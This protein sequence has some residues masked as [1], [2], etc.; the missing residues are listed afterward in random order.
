VKRWLPPNLRSRPRPR[1]GQPPE[2]PKPSRAEQACQAVRLLPASLRPN[3]LVHGRRRIAG[4][5][6]ASRSAL[7]QVYAVDL[8]RRRN[9]ADAE[10]PEAGNYSD[11]ESAIARAERQRRIG[12]LGFAIGGALVSAG[13]VRYLL[14]PGSDAKTAAG[15]WLTTDGGGAS[16]TRRF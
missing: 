12:V 7:A 14:L 15:A 13:V 5:G 11:H 16:F 2:Q 1:A 9:D 4:H 10:D 3:L 8:D 6:G